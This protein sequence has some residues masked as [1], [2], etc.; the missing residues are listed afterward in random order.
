VTA[1]FDVR[2]SFVIGA[3]TQVDLSLREETLK[4]IR[5]EGLEGEIELRVAPGKYRL[6]Q[7]V[8][9]TVEGKMAAFSRVVEVQ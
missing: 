3:E 9:E 1:L 7:V 4:R 5:A 6:R 2:E 8:Q